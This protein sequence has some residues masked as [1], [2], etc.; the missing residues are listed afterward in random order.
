MFSSIKVQFVQFDFL[1]LK[2]KSLKKFLIKK[3]KEIAFP[4]CEFCQSDT[5]IA[6]YGTICGWVHQHFTPQHLVRI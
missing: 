1:L 6:N 2:K 3:F 4:F 5:E